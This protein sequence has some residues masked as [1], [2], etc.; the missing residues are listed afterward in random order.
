VY[1]FTGRTDGAD[2]RTGLIHDAAGNLCGTT[3]HDGRSDRN[4]GAGCGTVF[5]GDKSGNFTVLYSFPGGTDGIPPL[6]ALTAGNLSGTT[7]LGGDVACSS[8]G[9]DCGTVSKIDS[10]GKKSVLHSFRGLDRAYPQAAV[11]RDWAVNLYGTTNNGGLGN[12]GT[13]FKIAP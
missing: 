9:F 4:E 1:S 2:P 11:I 3:L 6:G 7:S 8:K 10:P 12:H 5:K 13:V